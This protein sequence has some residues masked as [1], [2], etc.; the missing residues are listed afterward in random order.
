LGKGFAGFEFGGDEIERLAHRSAAHFAGDQAQALLDGQTRSGQLGELLVEDEKILASQCGG[1]GRVGGGLEL[2]VLKL[3]GN[4]TAAGIVGIS[5][6][7]RPG[8]LLAI[9]RLGAVGKRLGTLVLIGHGA[10]GKA[11]A[12]EACWLK[13]AAE[14][15][16]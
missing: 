12:A 5:G 16:L 10:V 6:I 11:S 8:N 2:D 7:N 1:A 4:Q 9:P 14:D 13:K 3:E 15:A